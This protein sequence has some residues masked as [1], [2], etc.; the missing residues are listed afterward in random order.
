MARIDG[1]LDLGNISAGAYTGFAAGSFKDYHPQAINIGDSGNTNQA[2]FTNKIVGSNWGT[3]NAMALLNSAAGV[4]VYWD[5][6][7][8]M[9]MV[10]GQSLLIAANSIHLSVS[11]PA[12]ESAGT[13]VG[14]AITGLYGLGL[15][16]IMYAGAGYSAAIFR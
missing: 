2:L 15:S 11:A 9:S 12:T 16:G 1:L 6:A 5:L 13:V 10:A 4:I 14:A 7:N 3:F 8:M